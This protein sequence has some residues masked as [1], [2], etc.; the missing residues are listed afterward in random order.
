MDLSGRN[1]KKGNGSGSKY[2]EAV[3]I[4]TTHLGFTFWFAEDTS[5]SKQT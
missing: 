4:Q 1:R 3:N 2:V 5:G